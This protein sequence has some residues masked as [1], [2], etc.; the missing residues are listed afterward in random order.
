MSS[1]DWPIFQMAY[2]HY[3]QMQRHSLSKLL[4]NC[5]HT[6]YQQH[7]INASN[8]PTCPHCSSVE[9]PDHVYQCI[10][11]TIKASKQEIIQQLINGL[12]QINT[13]PHTLWF[14]QTYFME[15]IDLGYFTNIT[16]PSSI[17][18][19]RLDQ[20]ILDQMAIG[21]QHVIRGRLSQQ[22][23]KLQVLHLQST[24]ATSSVAHDQSKK[25]GKALVTLLW[26][27]NIAIWT[28]RNNTLHAS[29][30]THHA[31]KQDWIDERI[32]FHYQNIHNY[33]ARFPPTQPLFITPIATRLQEHIQSKVKWLQ[34]I[35]MITK[36]DS[37]QKNI[38]SE[39]DFIHQFNSLE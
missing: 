25:W 14:F 16:P 2:E 7:R 22:W 26:K 29:S 13:N 23:R 15:W 17:C 36:G 12:H 18:H 19:P 10:S 31:K 11:P 20:A 38:P 33:T 32:H 37:S 3:P 5:H 39:Y 27:T 1:I 9:T 34:T 21:M 4:Y 8:A 35:E 24:S 30:N 28:L 6:A